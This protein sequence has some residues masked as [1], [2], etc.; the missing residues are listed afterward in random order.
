MGR[1][2]RILY[3]ASYLEEATNPKSLLFWDIV[4]IYP[5]SEE[6]YLMP[7]GVKEV[8]EDIIFENHNKAISTSKFKKQF[9][10]DSTFLLNFE[11]CS[12]TAIKELVKYLKKFSHV[13][14]Y[15][16][17]EESTGGGESIFT[18]NIVS[19]EKETKITIRK[20][21]IGGCNN[22]LDTLTQ[23]ICLEYPK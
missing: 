9:E 3:K 16:I 21:C 23:N 22:G 20:D 13:Y 5:G 18:F 11:L 1:R 14:C 10:P 15:F 19:D 4:E 2:T 6:Y 7:K 8:G 17:I 12:E